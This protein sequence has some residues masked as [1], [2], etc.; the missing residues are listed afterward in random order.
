MK[1]SAG[2]LLSMDEALEKLLAGA[3]APGD[4]LDEVDLMEASGRVLA[5]DV[6]S[7]LNVP[8]VDNSSMDGYAVRTADI[9]LFASGLPVS[10]RIPAGAVPVPLAP[11]TVARIF[12]GA[13]VPAGADAIVIQEQ[14]TVAGERVTLRASPKAGEWIRVIGSDIKEGSTILTSGMRLRAQ[15]VALA[16]SVGRASLPVRPLLRVATFF[17]GDELAMPGEPL[18]PGKIYNSNR[19]LLRGMLAALPVSHT[20]LGIVVDTLD[21]TRA[22]LREAAANHDLIITSGG[23]SVGEEDHVKPAVEAEGHID[24]WSLAIKPGKPL[25]SG[26]VRRADGSEAVFIG[27]PGNPVSS[28]VTFALFVRPLLLRMAGVAHVT[29]VRTPMRADFAWPKADRR[30]EFLRVRRNADGGLDLFPNQLS[31]VLTSTV[32]ADGIIDNPA[33]QVIAKGDIV[34]FISFSDLLA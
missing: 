18:A 26:R 6:T 9:P 1:G 16:A 31:S 32:W 20:D 24:L 3:P 34:Q 21:A 17:T 7:G 33:G 10:Q 25:A 5:V 19:Y 30:R 23:V 28:F 15:D 12:T 27:L 2:N 29:P 22:T 11:Q 8:S 13:E 4:T 14:V